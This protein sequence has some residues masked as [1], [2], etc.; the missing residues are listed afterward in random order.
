MRFDPWRR[1]RL[2]DLAVR[3]YALATIVVGIAFLIILGKDLL[4]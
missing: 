2:E 4:S 3:A 1:E